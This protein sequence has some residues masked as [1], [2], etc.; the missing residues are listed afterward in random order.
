MGG[1]L[2]AGTAQQPRQQGAAASTATARGQRSLRI[3]PPAQP[4][5]SPSP[6][7]PVP[8]H[9]LLLLPQCGAV[10][11]ARVVGQR[12]RGEA[13]V[14]HRLDELAGAH[15]VGVVPHLWVGW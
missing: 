5:I 3:F 8:P 2:G 12:L 11:L 7:P 1:R 13:G 4:P 14:G 10:H 6:C 9:L 15:P